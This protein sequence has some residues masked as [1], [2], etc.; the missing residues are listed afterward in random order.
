MMGSELRN[1]WSFLKRLKR[2]RCV[3]VIAMKGNSICTII[4]HCYYV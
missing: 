2:L 1:T 4:L 3:H